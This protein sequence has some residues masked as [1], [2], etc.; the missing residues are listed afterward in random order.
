MALL[1]L[2]VYIIAMASAFSNTDQA[3]IPALF[4]IVLL[5]SA[6]IVWQFIKWRNTQRHLSD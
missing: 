6:E 3:L 5:M 2:S 4:A 1:P